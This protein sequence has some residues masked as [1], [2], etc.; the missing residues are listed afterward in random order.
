MTTR[1]LSLWLKWRLSPKLFAK[2]KIFLS[3]CLSCWY[4]ERKFVGLLTDIFVMITSIP[5]VLECFIDSVSSVLLSM[6]CLMKLMN[7]LWGIAGLIHFEWIWKDKFWDAGTVWRE[8]YLTIRIQFLMMS[9]LIWFWKGAVIWNPMGSSDK[10]TTLRLPKQFCQLGCITLKPYSVVSLFFLI[11][12]NRN[13]FK[14]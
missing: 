6:I 14:I 4:K 5:E 8:V 2:K 13:N 9:C 12:L 3:N 1:L 11:Y 7:K 10:T